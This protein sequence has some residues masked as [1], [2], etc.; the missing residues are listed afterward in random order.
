LVFQLFTLLP[1]PVWQTA[2]SSMS[3][4]NST[5]EKSSDSIW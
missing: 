1:P 4:V 2:Q 5:F 3:L